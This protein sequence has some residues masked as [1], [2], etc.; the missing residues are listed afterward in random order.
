MTTPREASEPQETQ[1]PEEQVQS[2]VAETLTPGN[3]DTAQAVTEKAAE[4]AKRI[5]AG[6]Q[7]GAFFRRG[8]LNRE[9]STFRD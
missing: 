1:E 2:A 7:D 6:E 9:P 5:H 4:V 8:L 3:G